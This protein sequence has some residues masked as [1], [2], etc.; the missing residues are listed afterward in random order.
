MR[1]CVGL[2]EYLG[3][4]KIFKMVKN[5]RSAFKIFIGHG[6]FDIYGRLN[7]PINFDRIPDIPRRI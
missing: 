2:W 4:Q 1:V 7:D 3:L 5:L 6:R